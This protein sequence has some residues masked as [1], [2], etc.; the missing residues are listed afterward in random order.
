M[1]KCHVILNSLY[2]F[3]QYILCFIQKWRTAKIHG[4]DPQF[5]FHP[6]SRTDC[7]GEF[8]SLDKVIFIKY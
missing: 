6:S 8:M 1:M 2:I 5:S 4:D 7:S 3:L